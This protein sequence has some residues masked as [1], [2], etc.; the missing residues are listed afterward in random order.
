M[1]TNGSRTEK[2]RRELRAAVILLNEKNDQKKKKT[3]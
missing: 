2:E 1:D 3:I